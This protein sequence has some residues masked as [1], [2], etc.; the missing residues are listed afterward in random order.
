MTNETREESKPKALVTEARLDVYMDGTGVNLNS[1][2][3]DQ[4]G[5]SVVGDGYMQN[6]NAKALDPYGPPVSENVENHNAKIYFAGP[7]ASHA[8]YSEDGY[9]LSIPTP[10]SM[11]AMIH[12]LT[13]KHRVSNHTG[14]TGAGAE[15]NLHMAVE[16]AVNYI[17]SLP[18]DISDVTIAVHGYS[19]G[20]ITAIAFTNELSKR[21][22]Q[23]TFQGKKIKLEGNLIDPVAGNEDG[24]YRH[25][26]PKKTAEGL[27]AVQPYRLG[28]Q[29]GE[30]TLHLATQEKREP[31]KPQLPYGLDRSQENNRPLFVPDQVKLNVRMCHACHQTIAYS[32]FKGS[33]DTFAAGKNTYSLMTGKGYESTLPSSYRDMS[34]TG[35]AKYMKNEARNIILETSTERPERTMEYKNSVLHDYYQ[36]YC[37]AYGDKASFY[38]ALT[39]KDNPHHEMATWAYF[40][41]NFYHVMQKEPGNVNKELLA[42]AVQCEN[43]YELETLA[44]GNKD[45]IDNLFVPDPVDNQLL[46]KKLSFEQ[47]KKLIILKELH[48]EGQLNENYSSY[49]NYVSN[50]MNENLIENPVNR[51]ID[52]LYEVQE[53]ISALER[54]VRS[55]ERR[56]FKDAKNYLQ[57]RVGFIKD[58]MNQYKQDG[59]A[60]HLDHCVAEAGS[61]MQHEA[62][63]EHR[64]V[65]RILEALIKPLRALGLFK[66]TLHTDSI[67][68]SMALKQTLFNLK[69]VVKKPKDECKERHQFRYDN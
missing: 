14:I 42:K 29:P 6:T 18:D 12:G 34:E 26:A 17:N 24:V 54:K 32:M 28:T 7:A 47:R 1:V 66:N 62:L 52:A 22:Q 48:Y 37:Q 27:T 46:T 30:Y 43:K 21:L 63:S 69:D 68:K 5:P 50:F 40:N 58:E 55:L 13:A 23:K 20:G 64:G 16:M 41:S 53:Q 33:D 67:K 59:D 9:N 39:N 56:G 35:N 65:K 31:F 61:L 3:E 38:D 10:G 49:E 36:F 19:R 44:K 45:H 60:E 8:E 57:E 4:F 11:Q 25:D 51:K 15:H 2:V